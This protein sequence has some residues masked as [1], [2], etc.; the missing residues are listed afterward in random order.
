VAAGLAGGVTRDSFRRAGP[1]RLVPPRQG[2]RTRSAAPG[3]PNSFRPATA[4]NFA[5]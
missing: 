3:P 4:G 5:H 1:V 2:R